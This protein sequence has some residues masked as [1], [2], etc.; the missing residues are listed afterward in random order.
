MFN[1]GNCSAAENSCYHGKR[2]TTV[3]RFLY[4]NPANAVVCLMFL[5]MQKRET[6]A[7]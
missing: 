5:G 3:T 4:F 6:D 2:K 7:M 1:G